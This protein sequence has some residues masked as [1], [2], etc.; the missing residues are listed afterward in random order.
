MIMSQ[1]GGGGANALKLQLLQSERGW[2]SLEETR[3]C[4]LCEKTFSGR[5]VR[6]RRDRSGTSHLC[7]P[8][9]R[10]PSTPA[11]W[12]HP[13]NPLISEEAWRDWVRL[14]DTLCEESMRPVFFLSK[15]QLGR[16]KTSRKFGRQKRAAIAQ[17]AECSAA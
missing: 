12:V 14:L 5:Q 15:R 10:C 7:C 2:A 17:T 16:K 13:G 6:V 3:Q 11:Q 1:D 4:V 8:T 9:P